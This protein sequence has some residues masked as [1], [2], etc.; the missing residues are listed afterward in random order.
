L[1]DQA[2][3]PSREPREPREWLAAL[4]EPFAQ[5]V[6]ALVLLAAGGVVSLYLAWRGAARVY[7]FVAPQMPWLMS[8]GLGGLAVLGMA[9]A[10]WSIHL[11][12]RADAEA[13]VELQAVTRGFVELCEGLRAGGRELAPKPNRRSARRKRVNSP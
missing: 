12:R 5:A 1:S 3:P 8:G 10:A 6:I 13:K 7:G 2:S 9:L 11:S 4:R